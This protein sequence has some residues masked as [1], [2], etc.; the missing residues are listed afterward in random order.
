MASTKGFL[1][2]ALPVHCSY[3]LG[4]QPLWA[5]RSSRLTEHQSRQTLLGC[6]AQMRPQVQFLTLWGYGQEQ[7]EDQTQVRRLKSGFV[8]TREDGQELCIHPRVWRKALARLEQLGRYI[9]GACHLGERAKN[10]KLSDMR[11]RLEST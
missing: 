7:T 4:Q 6:P 3:P 5:T 10:K 9:I 2:G 1:V 11:K 8:H